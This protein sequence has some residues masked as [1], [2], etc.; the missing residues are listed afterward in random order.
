MGTRA[1]NEGLQR[2]HIRR[3]IGTPTTTNQNKNLFQTN[4]PFLLIFASA[5][6]FYVYLPWV[7]VRLIANTVRSDQPA[8]VL[9][10]KICTEHHVWSVWY[11]CSA[12][13]VEQ[14]IRQNGHNAQYISS[15]ATQLLAGRISLFIVSTAI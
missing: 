2:F 7:N 11:V 3:V 12:I 13:N 6:Q 15:Y 9:H 8:I 14:T 5:S 4:H 10:K 1:G